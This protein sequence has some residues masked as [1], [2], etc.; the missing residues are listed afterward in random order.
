M[1]LVKLTI[2][3]S[4]AKADIGEYSR[5]AVVSSATG[6][7][8]YQCWWRNGSHW[9]LFNGDAKVWEEFRQNRGAASW[10]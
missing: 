5:L 4:Y 7:G 2:L 10:G 1:R 3:E 8:C 6:L 9:L